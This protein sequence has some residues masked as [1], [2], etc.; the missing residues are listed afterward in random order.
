M[1]VKSLIGLAVLAGLGAVAYEL[2]VFERVADVNQN[3]DAPA[4]ANG[5]A[6]QTPKVLAPA[7]TTARVREKHFVETVLVTG[8]LVPQEEIL[9]A[10]EISGLRVQSLK[11]EEGDRVKKGDILAVLVS[12]QLDAQ[13]AQNDA[14]QAAAIASIAQAESSIADAKA[15]VLETSASLKRAKP[16]L[17]K[18]YLAQSTYE[19]RQAA[20]TSAVAQLSVAESQLR[21]ARAEKERV[22][23]QRRELIWRRNNTDVRAPEDG[24]ISRRTARIGEIA[25]GAA[26]AGEP[27]FRI[28]QDGEIELAAELPEIDMAKVRPGQRATIKVIGVGDVGGVVRLVSPEVDPATRLGRVKLALGT[29]PALRIGA[30]GN[31]TIETASS[32]GLAIPRSAILY[33]DSTPRV[34]VVQEGK[35][36]ARKIETGLASGDDVEVRKGLSKGELVVAKSGTFL[37]DGDEVRPI[38]PTQRLSEASE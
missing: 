12:E 15:R 35:V 17:N 32:D 24:I 18:K 2:G 23:A 34:L 26:G 1:R 37:R 22:E 30:F 10:P 36:V 38:I 16:L 25:G 29:N 19:Q 20:A 13:L 33:D 27:L 6:S 14:A 8:S 21:A 4:K 28:I 3:Q 5:K 9:V 7:V 11:A 31:G